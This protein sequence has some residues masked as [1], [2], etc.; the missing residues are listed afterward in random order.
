VTCLEFKHVHDFIHHDIKPSNFLTK[1]DVNDMSSIMIYL[2]DF[3]HAH[4]CRDH[5]TC[6]HVHFR[7]HMPF[8][9]TKPFT[10]VNAHSSIE[11]SCH[12]DIELL[13]YTLIYLLNGLLPW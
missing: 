1:V 5:K 10:S 3:G 13:A 11:L 9:G 6:H 4:T 8:I 2:I 12:D 7:E